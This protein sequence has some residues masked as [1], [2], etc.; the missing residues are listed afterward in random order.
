MNN[1]EKERENPLSYKQY[2]DHMK[3]ALKKEYLSYIYTIFISKL[4]I[5]FLS[6][7]YHELKFLKNEF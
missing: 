7:F 4:I 2:I 6:F 3:K 1:K 5:T